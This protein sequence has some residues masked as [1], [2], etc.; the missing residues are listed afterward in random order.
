MATDIAI[1]GKEVP[2]S[3]EQSIGKGHQTKDRSQ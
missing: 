2:A 1:G 3:E